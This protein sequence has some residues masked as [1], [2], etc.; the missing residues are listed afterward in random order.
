[1]EESRQREV[2]SFVLRTGRMTRAQ[3]RAIEKLGPRFVLS[4]EEVLDGFEATESGAEETVDRA[5]EGQR[6]G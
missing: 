6:S 3:E 1:M 5:G 2:R 4:P